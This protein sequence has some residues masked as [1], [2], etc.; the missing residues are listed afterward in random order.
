MSDQDAG[1]VLK[2]I[3]NAKS[4]WLA[5][6]TEQRSRFF[7]EKVL[8]FLGSMVESGAELLACAINDNT[9]TERIGYRYM[10]VWK[11]P[12]KVFSE[13]LEA[14]AKEFGFLQYFDQV[15]FSG[16]IIPPPVLNDDMIALKS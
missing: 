5:L 9:G 4:S 1:Y 11:L 12:D 8:P 2:E 7:E 10:A 6:S 14:G 15:N 16:S 3:W 13:K